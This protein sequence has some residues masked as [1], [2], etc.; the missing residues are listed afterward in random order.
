MYNVR[1][2]NYKFIEVSNFNLIWVAIKYILINLKYNRR[3]I[4]FTSQEN[5]P[6]HRNHSKVFSFSKKL[7]LFLNKRHLPFW[8]SVFPS[9]LHLWLWKTIWCC[10]K[11]QRSTEISYNCTFIACAINIPGFILSAGPTSIDTYVLL[12]FQISKGFS[13]LQLA[14]SFL[15]PRCL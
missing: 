11:G 13:H 9:L 4:L 5:F 1:E 14:F 10:L 6:T 3:K 12:I 15:H 2:F 7:N 8:P